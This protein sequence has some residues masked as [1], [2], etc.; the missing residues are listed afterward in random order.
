MKPRKK[1]NTHKNPPLK[2]LQEKA[3]ATK[4]PPPKY[5]PTLYG[6]HAVRAA[7]L[8][9]QREVQALYLTAQAAKSFED[10]LQDA[11]NL[12]ISRPDITIVDKEMLDKFLPRGAVHQGIGLAS[13]VPPEA[14]LQDFLIQADG[15]ERSVFVML[16]QVTDPHNVGAILRSASAFGVHG[17]IMQKKHA[18]LL[19]GVLAK[20]ACGAVEH[21]GVAQ[22]T[23]LSRALEDLRAAGF[24]VIGLDERGEL[25]LQEAVRNHAPQRI[26]LVLGAEGDGIRRLIRENCDILVRLPTRGAIASLNVSNAAAVAFY[27]VLDGA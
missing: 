12:N 18:P 14:D 4:I 17:V 15:R 24:Y 7:W 8:N 11:K 27:A 9:P 25:T 22:E 16:D 6:F 3:P 5:P 26:V 19:D 13:N 23:N 21:I 20:T 2:K 10:A 1:Q